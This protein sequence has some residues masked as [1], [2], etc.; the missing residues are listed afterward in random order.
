M[1]APGDTP[2][3]IATAIADAINATAAADAVTDLPLEQV[4]TA[5]AAAGVVTITANST[6]T[7]FTLAVSVSAGGY[8]AGRQVAP[9]ADDGYGDFLSDPSQTL[10]GHE[11]TLCAACNLTGAEFALITTP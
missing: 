4:V 6:T 8:T 3:T 2:S 11:P 1:A 10:F 9:F 5:S 7:P